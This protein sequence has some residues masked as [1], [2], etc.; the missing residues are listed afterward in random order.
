MYI[1]YYIILY[2][3]KMVSPPLNLNRKPQHTHKSDFASPLVTPELD[4]SGMKTSFPRLERDIQRPSERSNQLFSCL[5][6][7]NGFMAHLSSWG[8]GFAC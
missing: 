2:I 4:T 1:L 7:E 8:P 6:P 5:S 3:L